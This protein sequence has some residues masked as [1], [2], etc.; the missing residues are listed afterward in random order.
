MPDHD[1]FHTLAEHPDLIDGSEELD[2]FAAHLHDCPS[3]AHTLL[4]VQD[5]KATLRRQLGP[6]CQCLSKGEMLRLRRAGFNPA[7]GAFATPQEWHLLVC[8]TCAKAYI[9]V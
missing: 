2:A 6:G 5:F 1:R 8:S 3:C 9:A 4:S 7:D